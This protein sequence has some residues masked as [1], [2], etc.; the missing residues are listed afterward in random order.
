MVPC[1][2]LMLLQGVFFQTRAMRS[3]SSF[4]Y[5]KR[6]PESDLSCHCT[7]N[8]ASAHPAQIATAKNTNVFSFDRAVSR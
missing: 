1:K 2:T 4:R 5:T 3:V 8:F 6:P 7:E